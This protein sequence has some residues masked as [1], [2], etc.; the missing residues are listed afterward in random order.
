MFESL[1][2]FNIAVEIGYHQEHGTPLT[3][4]QL[5]LRDIAAFATVRKRLER[6][7]QAGIVK[8]SGTLVEADMAELWLTGEAS[9]MFHRYLQQIE[10]LTGI[11]R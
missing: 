3:L 8:K 9:R 2:D 5:S 11:T 10:R 4:R 6:L 1:V 7:I